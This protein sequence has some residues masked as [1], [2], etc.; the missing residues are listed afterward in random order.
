MP[1]AEYEAN[2]VHHV[3]TATSIGPGQR[4]GP[5]STH[6]PTHASSH[7]LVRQVVSTVANSLQTRWSDGIEGLVK[8][9]MSRFDKY[10]SLIVMEAR[11]LSLFNSIQN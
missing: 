10:Q 9:P 3:Y 11:M 7:D 2:R 5:D 1:W 8:E 4:Q 6:Q